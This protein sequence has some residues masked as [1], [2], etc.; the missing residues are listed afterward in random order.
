MQR[1]GVEDSLKLIV[2]HEFKERSSF[3]CQNLLFGSF[4]ARVF[5]TKKMNSVFRQP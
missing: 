4:V 5:I 2:K 3:V 1:R